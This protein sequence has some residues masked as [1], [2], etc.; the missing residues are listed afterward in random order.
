MAIK[1][2]DIRVF[3]L[4]ELAFDDSLEDSLNL[5]TALKQS[6][7]K[8]KTG[9]KKTFKPLRV[10]SDASLPPLLKVGG[11]QIEIG[12]SLRGKQMSEILDNSE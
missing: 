5:I 2:T 8:K 10:T 6:F 1:T 11:G 9:K 7:Y 4:K 3:F 12:T